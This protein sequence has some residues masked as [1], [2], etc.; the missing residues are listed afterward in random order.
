MLSRQKTHT[1]LKNNNNNMMQQQQKRRPK[2]AASA[3][4]RGGECVRERTKR[5]Q[6]NSYLTDN[7]KYKFTEQQKVSMCY[8]FFKKPTAH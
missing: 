6:W 7:T 3:A 5:P 8:R 1:G 2:T 4:G